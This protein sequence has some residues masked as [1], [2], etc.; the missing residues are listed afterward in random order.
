MTKTAGVL[1]I[2]VA[3]IVLFTAIANFSGQCAAAATVADQFKSQDLTTT[4][5]R[6]SMGVQF[7]VDIIVVAVIAIVGWFLFGSETEQLAYVAIIGLLVLGGATIRLTPLVPITMARISPTVFFMG[8]QVKVTLTNDDTTAYVTLPEGDPQTLRVG[9]I[10]GP[11]EKQTEVLLDFRGD[12]TLFNA[13][14]KGPWPV[15]IIGS[16][17]GTRT[18]CNRTSVRDIFMVPRVKVFRVG[19]E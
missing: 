14:W 1:F 10:E 3:A 19:A 17:A 2:V 16:M 5:L 13:Y 6:W 18:L 8:T 7:L 9:R 11:N 12:T 4:D 15:T